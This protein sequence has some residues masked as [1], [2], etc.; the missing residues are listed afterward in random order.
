MTMKNLN[1]FIG[2]EFNGESPLT[3]SNDTLLRF[4]IELRK[5]VLISLVILSIIFSVLFYFANSLYTLLA[6]PLLKHLP[7]G[8]GLIAT[9]I[10]APFFVP[11]ELTFFLAIFLSM[12][13]F[14]HQLWLFIAPALYQ[15]EKKLLWPLL[16]MSTVLFYAGIAFSYFII[17][18][19]IF[20]FLTKTAP[21]GVIVSPDISSYLDFTLKLFLVFGVIFE[22]PI[23]TIVIIWSGVISREKLITIRPYIIVAAF[24]LGMLLGPP[25]VVSQTLLAVP[26]WL[27]YELGLFLAPI[28]VKRKAVNI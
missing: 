4:L 7:H 27:L 14:L 9:N 26:L 2:C 18:P 5:R 15:H 16:L 25:D 11:V 17:F 10:A 3:E 8:Q 23:I 12:P 24:V 22:V 20:A 6:L 13:F 28:F 21:L 19:I 1:R